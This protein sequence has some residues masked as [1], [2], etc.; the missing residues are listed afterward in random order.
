M[1]PSVIVAPHFRTMAEIFR[2]TTLGRLESVADVVWAVDDPMPQVEFEEA[3]RD[4][5]AVV[6]GTWHYGDALR[7]RGSALRAVLEVAGAHDHRDLGYE[8]CLAAGIEVGSVAPAFGAAVAEYGLAL[9]LTVSR[10]IVMNDREFRNGE[11]LWLHAGNVGYNTLFHRTVGFVGCGGLSR[12]L[13][14]LLEP[15]EVNLLGFDPFI[16]DPVLSARGI[17]PVDLETMFRSSEVIFILAAP[18]ASGR[19]L[20]DRRLLELLQPRQTVVLLSRAGLV[21]FDSLTSLV[22]AGRFRL[23]IDV[24]PEEPLPADHLL[25]G[26]DIA[27]LSSHRAG[28]VPDALLQ[29]GDMVVQDLEAMIAGSEERCLQYL[30]EEALPGLL[31]PP[32]N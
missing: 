11:E 27:V 24:Y 17:E 4:A 18:S 16:S 32:A 6:F 19:G 23:A 7:R 3:L 28:A 8:D 13:Q 20:I 21:D 9:A 12:H 31:Q 22:V 30:T 10:G 25:R 5:V 14:R 15:F 29:I 1:K 26:A 2:P